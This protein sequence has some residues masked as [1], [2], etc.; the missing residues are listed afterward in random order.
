[1][2]GGAFSILVNNVIDLFRFHSE[3]LE[4]MLNEFFVSLAITTTNLSFACSSSLCTLNSDV[5]N[6]SHL[7]T[8]DNLSH[9]LGGRS[10]L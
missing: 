4:S 3:F 7:S 1:M 9:L 6:L 5:D 10:F 2:C 8:V